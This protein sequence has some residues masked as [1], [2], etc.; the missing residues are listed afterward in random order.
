MSVAYT[1]AITFAS[2]EPV[3]RKFHRQGDADVMPHF[4]NCSR[5]VIDSARRLQ[6]N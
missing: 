2:P 4:D 3:F 6:S 5:I 1:L